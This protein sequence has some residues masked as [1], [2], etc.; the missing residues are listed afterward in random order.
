MNLTKEDGIYISK[1]YEEY[2][3]HLGRIEDYMREQKLDSLKNISSSLYP[4]EDDLFTDF[5]MHPNDMDFDI[6]EIPTKQWESML[7]ITSS[8]INGASPGRNI[9]LAV[10]E[11][12]TD[13]FVGFIRMGSPVINC[14][15]RNELLGQVFTSTKEGASRFNN[16]SMMGFAIVPSQPFGYNYLGGKL[17][18]LICCSHQ[19]R[20]ICNKKYNMNLCLFETT[21]LY[22]SSKSVS[23]YDGLKPYI[24]FGGIT[25]SNFLPSMYGKPYEDL[26]DFVESKVGKIVEDG[27]S[28]RKMKISQRIIALTKNALKGTDEL[29]HFNSIL[30]DAKSLTE[31]KRY[32]YS[33]YGYKNYIDYVN[34]KTDT[35][36][37]DP[38]NFHKFELENMINWWKKKASNRYETLKSEGR[39]RNEIEVWTSGKEI[40]IIR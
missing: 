22:G 16:A 34:N 28:S 10:K 14:K 4:P 8:H 36:I 12:N 17:L 6:V 9:R 1:V 35:L 13:K 30:S 31:K 7:T 3:G 23:Q 38:E 5:K 21:S 2:F 40:D 39:L 15:P 25:E 26:K 20:E 18:S 32:Y 37:E 24:R 27:V 11:R 33:N 19:M 29:H